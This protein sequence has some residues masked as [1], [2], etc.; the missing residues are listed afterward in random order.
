MFKKFLQL[1]VFHLALTEIV[2][3]GNVLIWPTDCSHWLNIKILLEELSQRN[4]SVTVLT[5]STT[6]FINSTPDA[7]LHFEEIPVSYKKSNIEEIIEH[8]IS[9]WLNHR[10]TPLTMWTFYKEL[11]KLFEAFYKINTQV[12]DGVLNNPTLMA[13]LQ[14]ASFDVLIADPVT[15]CGDL[16]AL[17]LGIPF[18]YTMRFS[19]AFTVERHCGKIPSPFSYVPAALSELSDQMSFGERVK[20][21]L[22]YSL[23]DFIFKSYWGGWNSYYSRVLGESQGFSPVDDP[24]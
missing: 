15:I 23:Q 2:L 24:R 16:V 20:N 22:S 4:H 3:S 18:V 21:T 1:F 9:L 17:K 11:G 5:S 8:M 12:C 13:K 10:P 6:L 14:K 19:P 7:F